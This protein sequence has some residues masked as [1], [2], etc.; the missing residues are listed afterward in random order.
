MYG[1]FLRIIDRTDENSINQVAAFLGML[2]LKYERSVEYTIVI[3]L[4]ECEEIIGT[5]SF[6]GNIIKCIGISPDYQSEGLGAE[7]LT[8]LVQELYER[9]RTHILVFTKPDNTVIFTGIGF[10]EIISYENIVT[11]LELGSPS[12]G[13]FLNDLEKNADRNISNP[14]SVF[15]KADL[16]NEEI[17]QKLH[18]KTEDCEMVYVF[19]KDIPDERMR[20]LLEKNANLKILLSPEYLVC[21]NEMPSYF[22]GNIT[23]D[24]IFY[25]T[26]G[27]FAGFFARYISSNLSSTRFLVPESNFKSIFTESLKKNLTGFGITLEVF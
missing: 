2:N 8:A 15:L 26:G 3:M 20:R 22:L 25:I 21:E 23:E 19:I 16:L 5:G 6:Q 4:E 7:I 18:L 13:D 9:G 14:P 10:K 1:S 24:K 12:L 11:M 17:I 27:L